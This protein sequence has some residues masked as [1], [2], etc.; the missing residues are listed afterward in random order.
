MSFSISIFLELTMTADNLSTQFS[1]FQRELKSFL[2]R[3]TA[4]VQG[5]ENEKPQ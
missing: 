4:S 2:L 5:A 1:S 3:L